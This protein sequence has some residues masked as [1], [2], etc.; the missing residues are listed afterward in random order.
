[1]GAGKI[2]IEY[3]RL[4]AKLSLASIHPELTYLIMRPGYMAAVHFHA[5]LA[6]ASP[7]LEHAAFYKRIFGGELW[8]QPREYPGL[9]AKFACMGSDFHTVRSVIEVRYPFYKSTASERQALFGPE[10]GGPKRRLREASAPD[11]RAQLSPCA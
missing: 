11:S 10:H 8:C 9:T 7:R 3:T 4:A 5:D 1:M 6:I 2:V